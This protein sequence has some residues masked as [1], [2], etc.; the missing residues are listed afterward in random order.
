MDKNFV[1]KSTSLDLGFVAIAD[2]Y[3]K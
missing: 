3:L 1:L 2:N